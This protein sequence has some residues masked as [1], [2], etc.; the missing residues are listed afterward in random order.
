MKITLKVTRSQFFAFRSALYEAQDWADWGAWAQLGDQECYWQTVSG[1]R[2]YMR[3]CGGHAILE[4]NVSRTSLAD[5][6]GG[7]IQIK[8][9]HQGWWFHLY[10]G[11]RRP[12]ILVGFESAVPFG[13]WVS[14]DEVHAYLRELHAPVSVGE[15]LQLWWQEERELIPAI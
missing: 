7:V 6:A 8:E 1:Y 12:A 14:D 15:R 2:Y 3:L 9:D 11:I 5:G 10:D 4:T 13:P